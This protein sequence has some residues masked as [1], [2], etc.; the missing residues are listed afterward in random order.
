MNP[1]NLTHPTE[2]GLAAEISSGYLLIDSPHLQHTLPMSSHVLLC[3]TVSMSSPLFSCLLSAT[4]LTALHFK[5][6]HLGLWWLA[7]TLPFKSSV[8][9]CTS[10]Q[11]WCVCGGGV[12][13]RK[14]GLGSSLHSDMEIQPRSK[15]LERSSSRCRMFLYT[16]QETERLVVF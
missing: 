9:F 8:S 5:P 10:V 13:E 4:G 1:F 6:L 12:L 3:P 2:G 11:R 15:L 16:N 7:L 14:K